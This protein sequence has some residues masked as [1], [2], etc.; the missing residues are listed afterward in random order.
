MLC[1][2][3]LVLL[4]GFVQVWQ[5]QLLGRFVPTL[6]EVLDEGGLAH[7][8]NLGIKLV[9]KGAVVKCVLTEQFM[10]RKNWGLGQFR[11]SS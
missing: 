4:A 2:L 3:E 5:L 1:C 9:K 8:D 11:E 10:S 7:F 6:G